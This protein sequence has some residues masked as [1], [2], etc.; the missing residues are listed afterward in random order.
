M[1]TY[2][3]M[4]TTGDDGPLCVGMTILAKYPPAG[5]I[6]THNMMIKYINRQFIIFCGCLLS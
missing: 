4:V 3:Y 6:S 2:N 1:Y 5:R